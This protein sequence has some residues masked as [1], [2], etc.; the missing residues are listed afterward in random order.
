MASL[1]IFPHPFRSR[2][3]KLRH[4]QAISLTVISVI[5]QKLKSSCW[6]LGLERITLQIDCSE[7]SVRLEIFRYSKLWHEFAIA[8]KPISFSDLNPPR[9]ADILRYSKFGYNFAISFRTLSVG[10]MLFSKSK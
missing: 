2:Y 4:E 8:D 3:F 10:S 7:N 1:L 5:L 6:S 9:K